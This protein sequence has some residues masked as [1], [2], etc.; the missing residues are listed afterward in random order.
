M[1]KRIVNQFELVEVKHDHLEG[2]VGAPRARDFFFEP[3]M[4]TARIRQPGE[5]IGERIGFR[6]RMMHCIGQSIR[7]QT[8]Y[9]FKQPDL[10]VTVLSASHR[11]NGNRTQQQIAFE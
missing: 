6:K 11:I 1:T 3:N 2:A 8:R 7:S 9:G 10:I 5:R 4:K